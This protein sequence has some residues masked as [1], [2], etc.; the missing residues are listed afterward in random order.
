MAKW[1]DRARALLRRKKE[2]REPLQSRGVSSR[3]DHRD[4]RRYPFGRQ[5][6]L[7]TEADACEHPV[8]VT[9]V[10]CGGV[11]LLA[12][13]ALLRG[14]RANVVLQFNGRYVRRQVEI[15]WVHSE[16]GLTKMGARFVPLASDRTEPFD[17]LMQYVR[18]QTRHA[19]A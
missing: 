13:R 17:D 12:D 3:T 19:A 9:D 6:A 11:C 8:K 5:A 2:D 1:W 10:A 14:D 18:W 15:R 4:S 7:F 16:G